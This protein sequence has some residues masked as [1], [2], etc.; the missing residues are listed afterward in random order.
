MTVHYTKPTYPPPTYNRIDAKIKIN[1][2]NNTR[3]LFEEQQQIAI[4]EI[5]T[6]LNEDD[7]PF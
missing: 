7:L 6:A 1:I 4:N 2:F 3:E 5:I